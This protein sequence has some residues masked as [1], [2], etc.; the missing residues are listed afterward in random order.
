[1]QVGVDNMNNKADVATHEDD[2]EKVVLDYDLVKSLATSLLKDLEFKQLV[3]VVQPSYIAKLSGLTDHID[4]YVSDLS[5]TVRA[6]K[7]KAIRLRRLQSIVDD[8]IE[9]VVNLE[10]SSNDFG[11]IADNLK[12]SI[13]ALDEIFDQQENQLDKFDAS[14]LFA[15]AREQESMNRKFFKDKHKSKN[16]SKLHQKITADILLHCSPVITDS[17][18]L[19]VGLQF[20]V[21]DGY[22]HIRNQRILMMD[23]TRTDNQYQYARKIA[24]ESQ[25]KYVPVEHIYYAEG[26]AYAWFVKPEVITNLL[27][28]LEVNAWCCVRNYR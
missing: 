8:L 10:L 19:R 28:G 20:R 2:D 17:A 11:D 4:D 27:S 16:K 12:Q 23:S 15:M 7:E 22:V 21:V 6:N 26:I 18:A 9:S 13:E 3:R 25:N 1:M 5:Y 14:T 24:L